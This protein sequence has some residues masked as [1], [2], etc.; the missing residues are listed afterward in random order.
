MNYSDNIE[1][2]VY[3]DNAAT[4][5]PSRESVEAGAQEARL[6]GNPSSLHKIGFQAEQRLEEYRTAVGDSLYCSPDEI[7][8]TS[9]G[10][11]ANNLAIF[12]A[13][14][15]NR[16]KG[17]RIVSTDS[18][19]PSVNEA[20]K[21][22]EGE[23]FEVVRLST[24]GGKLNMSEVEQALSEDT[25]LV[26][27]MHTNNETGAIY[28]VRAVSDLVRKKC[29]NAIMHCDCVQGYLKHRLSPKSLGVDLMSISS[30]KI[31][32]PKGAGA[33]YIK[34][35]IHILPQIVGGGQENGMRSGTESMMLI[36]AFAKAAKEGSLH[37]E[38][39]IEAVKKVREAIL[40]G[41]SDISG[42]TLNIADNPSPTILSITVR[43]N[44]SEVLLHKLSDRGIYVSSGS[45]CSSNSKRGKNS[46]LLAFGLTA[47]RADTTI[48]VSINH[49]NTVAEAERF[50]T[51][52]KEI[53]KDG[54]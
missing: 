43:A 25:I 12:G 28:D 50:C 52:L 22:L 41:L 42:I 39:N 1:E 21:R 30:H 19:H 47:T 23:G 51:A 11:E 26:S 36:A 5:K 9:G 29:P 37:L 33:L 49:T 32:A 7:C 4:S 18:E 27:V 46:V 20:L 48:R 15:K 10:T 44:K 6:F 45:A 2:I 3:F 53:I 16:R 17:N 38:E 54:K 31:C 8:F 14:Y 24:I 34:R 40:D 13:A 35:G